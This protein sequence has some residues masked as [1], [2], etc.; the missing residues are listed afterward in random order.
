MRTWVRS[1]GQ[2]KCGYCNRASRRGDPM[3]IVTPHP[4][5]G[6]TAKWLR[7]ASCAEGSPPADLP[8]LEE[9]SAITPTMLTRFTASSLPLD[10][11]SA[12]AGR[13]PGE[14]G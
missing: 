6:W 8:T 4:E 10:F 2:Q 9:K 1:Y 3:Q 11:K 12:A 5:R 14:D 13:E 7:C